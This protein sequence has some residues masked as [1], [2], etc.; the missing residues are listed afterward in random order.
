MKQILLAIAM[1]ILSIPSTYAFT[2]VDGMDENHKPIII[3][4]D[5][6]FIGSIL[7]NC[8]S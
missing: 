4:S 3:L 6:D 8:H 1:L 5:E 7:D 2:T